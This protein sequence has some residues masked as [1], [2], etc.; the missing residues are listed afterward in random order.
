MGVC[1][2]L[3]LIAAF[4][5]FSPEGE[6]LFLGGEIDTSLGLLGRMLL[7]EANFKIIIISFYAFLGFWTFSLFLHKIES[8]LVPL[9]LVFNSLLLSAISISPFLYSGLVLEIAVLISIPILIGDAEKKFEGVS[10]YLISYSIGMVFILLAG[11]YLAGGEI[12]PINDTQL[13]QATM[14]LGLGFIFWLAVFPVHTWI[15]ILSEDATP[16]NSFYILILLPLAVI[17]LLLK[18]LNGFSWLRSYTLVFDSLNLFGSIMCLTGAVWA[19]FQKS[20]RRAAGYLTLFTGGLIIMSISLQSSNGF[21]LATYLFL[22]RLFVLSMLAWSIVLIEKRNNY[23]SF[24]E[25]EGFFYDSPVI[26]AGF[27]FSLFSIAGMP[28]TPGYSPLQ[29]LL[30]YTSERNVVTAIILLISIL[31]LSVSFIRRLYFFMK[32]EVKQKFEFEE[33]RIKYYF[34]GFIFFGLLIGFFPGFFYS[35]FETIVSSYEFLVQ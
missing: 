1:G 31:L 21:I 7:I 4:S 25:L 19:I 29:T 3:I 9:G 33:N 12:S 2:F 8:Y 35:T 13:I 11:W 23:R 22:Q 30:A 32:N 18:Y 16:S 27:I 6:I 10:R 15:P 20:I 28:L 17:I 24:R 34:V 26:A 5:R 14:I